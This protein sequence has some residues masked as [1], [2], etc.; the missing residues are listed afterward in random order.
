[1]WHGLSSHRAKL[2][3]VGDG[4]WQERGLGDARLLLPCASGKAQSAMRH[5]DTGKIVRNFNFLA[6]VLLCQLVPISSG[7]GRPATGP[8]KTQKAETPRLQFDSKWL[9]VQFSDALGGEQSIRFLT[10]RL[11]LDFLLTASHGSAWVPCPG[12]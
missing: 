10:V 7:R 5:D 3:R 6:D 4:A 1:M 8:T 9:A 11:L 12:K 2:F